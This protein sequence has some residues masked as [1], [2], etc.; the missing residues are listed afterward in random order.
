M[1]QKEKEIK[2]IDENYDNDKIKTAHD[3]S[4]TFEATT[5]TIFTITSTIIIDDDIFIIFEW[6]IGRICYT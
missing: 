5:N 2:S 6:N 1:I 4:V 3:D